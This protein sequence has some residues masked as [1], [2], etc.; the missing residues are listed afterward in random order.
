MTAQDGPAVIVWAILAIWAALDHAI[1]WALLP[2]FMS[3][4]AFSEWYRM[5]KLKQRNRS[6][7]EKKG[8]A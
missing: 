5:R 7:T 1:F 6:V 2:A 4:R 3:G 8:Q